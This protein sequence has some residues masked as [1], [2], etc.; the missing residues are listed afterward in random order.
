MDTTWYTYICISITAI[1]AVN[2]AVTT[3][4]FPVSLCVVLFLW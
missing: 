1:Q 4:G 3:Q 2:I